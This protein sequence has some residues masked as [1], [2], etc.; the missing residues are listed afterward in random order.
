MTSW[1]THDPN[2]PLKEKIGCLQ[3]ITSTINLVTFL[4]GNSVIDARGE[5]ICVGYWFMQ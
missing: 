2:L 4:C 1:L 5:G 3:A